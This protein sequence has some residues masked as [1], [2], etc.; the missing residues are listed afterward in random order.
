MLPLSMKQTSTTT[1]ASTLPVNTNNV[2]IC[3]RGYLRVSMTHYVHWYV[4]LHR[5]VCILVL[6]WIYVFLVWEHCSLV[7]LRKI[8]VETKTYICL[9]IFP[10]STGVYTETNIYRKQTCGETPNAGT[11]WR[12]QTD[13]MQ[14]MS[15]E[16]AYF[17]QC[18]SHR[19]VM[20]IC[21]YYYISISVKVADNACVGKCMFW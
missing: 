11:D 20:L 5:Y 3:L 15:L 18:V 17:C 19:R 16:K 4:C 21:V 2:A 13:L 14:L 9:Q 10:H 1:Y 12:I 6:V 8:I 7:Y